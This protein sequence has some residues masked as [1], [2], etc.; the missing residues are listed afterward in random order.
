MDR[1]K[2]LIIVPKFEMHTGKKHRVVNVIPIGLASISA[3]LKEQGYQVDFL[4]LYLYDDMSEEGICKCL[5]KNE[6]D[7]I[8]TGGLSA[9]YRCV[10]YCVKLARQYAPRARIVLGGGI[11]TSQPQLMFQSLGPDFIVVGEGDV[12]I[13]ELLR[14][15][16]SHEDLAAVD[17]IG[18]R[19]NHGD[20][21]L[22]KPR[23]PIKDLDTLP[24]PDYE[25]LG[26]D[27]ILENTYPSHS[28]AYDWV[29]HPRPYSL[30]ASRSCP[31]LCTFCFHPIGNKYRQRSIP[32]IMAELEVAVN[33]Y[34][35]NN[36]DMYDELFSFDRQ[37]VYDLCR[38]MKRL[39]ESVN[40]EIRWNCQMRVDTTD[41][42]LIKT[43]KD[44]GCNLLLL[45]LESYSQVVLDSMRKKTTPQ[46][47]DNTLNLARKANLSVQG[48]FI[49]GDV[50]E[51]KETAN[52]TLTY[53]KNNHDIFG[54]GVSLDFIQLYPGTKLYKHAVEKKI[55]KDE[56]D[57]VEN[58]IFDRINVTEKIIDKDFDHLFTELIEA[59]FKYS[60]Y[61][62][63]FKKKKRNGVWEV[64]V[65]CPY[66]KN[67]SIYRN[68]IP[69]GFRSYH[70]NDIC[71][72][73]CR[74][75]FYLVSLPFMLFVYL[76]RII[77][78][79]FKPTLYTLMQFMKA[80]N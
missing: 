78:S 58:H 43:M 15:L 47:I 2:I 71:C 25:G 22:T 48:N 10:K 9:H 35:I 51:T 61:L 28:Y 36:I 41:E 54:A 66:C 21:V 27:Y 39:S 60:K 77:P 45:G 50:A 1:K 73:V 32:N 79:R 55:I 52:E 70:R 20:L 7:F 67:V 72:Q 69:P 57:F 31:F 38:E 11:I 3:V 46:Q 42:D 13:V 59:R 37:R 6:Y 17:G 62:L 5:I 63:P 76:F 53:W 12:T 44:A 29:E 56:I 18:F 19:D 14:Y 24:W 49:F 16:E 4:N 75:R 64:S 40:W 65:K 33:R 68:Y 74:L 34:R 26:I 80:L 30:L 8:L 23:K